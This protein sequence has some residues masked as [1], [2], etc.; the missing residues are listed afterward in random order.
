MMRQ[1]PHQS[2]KALVGALFLISLVLAPAIR[3]DDPGESGKTAS[4]A[5]GNGPY[6]QNVSMN[7]ITICWSTD[8]ASMGT[9]NYSKDQSFGQS[10][11]DAIPRTLHEV[12]LTGLEANTTYNYYVSAGGS[13]SPVS[14][15]R[16]APAGRVPFR[17]GAH[18]DTR[19]NHQNH[20]NIIRLMHSYRP[21]FYLHCGDLVEFGAQPSQWDTFFGIIS[22][23]ANDTAYWP[24]VGNHDT[25]TALYQLYF[26]LPGNELYYSFDYGAAHFIALDT[27]GDYSNGSTQNLWL[28]ADLDNASG[29]DWIFVFFHHPPYS[30]GAHGSTL[31]VRNVLCPLF[32]EH[33]V[34]AVFAGHDHDYEHADPGDGVQYF[35]T[36]GGG[37]PLNPVGKS[38]WT[39]YSESVYQFM[40]VDV[41]LEETVLTAIR[42]NGTVM[43]T[44]HIPL[45]DRTPPAPVPLKAVDTGIGGQVALDWSTYDEK[46]QGDVAQYRLYYSTIDFTDVGGFSPNATSPAGTS[47]ANV[48]GLANGTRYYFAVVAAD[49]VPN[50]DGRVTTVPAV[51]TDRTP[52]APPSGLRV[53]R[54]S[55]S[56]IDLVWN[57]SRESDLEGY[58]VY[59]NDSGAGTAGPFH[60]ITPLIKNISY[61]ADGLAMNTTYIFA[62]DAVD[63]ASPV[64]NN[65]SLSAL[66]I[67]TT[68]LLIPN[69]PPAVLLPLPVLRMAEDSNQPGFVEFQKIFSDPDGDELSY[70]LR[71]SPGLSVMASPNGNGIEVLPA[72]DWNGVGYVL[73]IASDLEYETT[74]NL[75]V[76][77]SPVNDPPLLYGLAEEWTFT[78]GL[79]GSVE[80]RAEDRADKDADLTAATDLAALLPG[81]GAGANYWL[82]GTTG[83]DG[84]VRFLLTLLPD[85]GM[86]GTYRCNV[87]VAD[88]GGAKASAY[89][90]MRILDVNAPPTVHILSPAEGQVFEANQTLTLI[91][92]AADED[93]IHGDTLH[94]EWWAAGGKL[95]GRGRELDGV[96][97]GAGN[98]TLTVLVRDDR[99]ASDR[100]TVNITVREKPVP[101]PPLPPPTPHVET[102]GGYPTTQLLAM[103]AAGCIAA[104]ILAALLLLS[105]RKKG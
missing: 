98:H 100:A 86:V 56:Y 80:F 52:P 4:R 62:V 66:V 5:I 97:L 89:V 36:G 13:Q 37:A 87:T 30:S 63:R 61:R 85:N 12:T 19:T 1:V 50:L 7:N 35:V 75:T 82:N 29:S 91:A 69:R 18:G 14:T 49:E 57:L 70:S 60:N 102:E 15:F 9:V 83:T 21:E 101:P 34:T 53:T 72:P 33:N 103:L 28:R 105:R 10:A 67:A 99:G 16:T 104:A 93:A 40:T 94:Y 51:P 81:L 90:T 42:E 46:A 54:A 41:G 79:T 64:P 48:S 71:A 38:S 45:R 24:S 23:Y 25:P 68:T 88:S 77:V 3:A 96:T 11:S 17:F 76:D 8:T 31:A 59:I 58:R 65:S 47:S 44:V 55:S 84:T 27:T 92:D 39:V 73:V 2:I 74:A 26:S 20:S 32:A 6:L 95:L 43:E 78:E 22:P